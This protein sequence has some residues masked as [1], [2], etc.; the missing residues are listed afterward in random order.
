[1]ANGVIFQLVKVS[2]VGHFSPPVVVWSGTAA[3]DERHIS[4]NMFI[5]TGQFSNHA[6]A[7]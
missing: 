5:L 4:C 2:V 6:P 7:T 3:A 1:M